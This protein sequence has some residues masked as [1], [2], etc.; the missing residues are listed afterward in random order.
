[1]VRQP[2][3]IFHHGSTEYT[4]FLIFNFFRVFRASVVNQE[5]DGQQRVK[6]RSGPSIKSVVNFLPPAA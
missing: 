3:G 1:M 6:R 4:E 2:A 5:L